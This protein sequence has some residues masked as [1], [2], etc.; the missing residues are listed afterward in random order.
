[1]RLSY[2]LTPLFFALTP[3]SIS[4]QEHNH[5][6]HEHSHSLGAHVHGVATL[7]IA[8]ENQQLEMQ[9]DSP[10]MNIVGFEYKPSSDA[11]KQAVADAERTLKNE[12]ALF[13]LTTAGQCA[14]SSMSID[15]DLI[16]QHDEHEHEH[17]NDHAHAVHSNE[18]DAH[19]H[20]DISAHYVFN[21][22]APSKLNSIDLAGFFKAFPKTEKINVQLVTAEAQNGVELSPSNTV[23]SW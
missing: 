11:D 2:L 14:L 7:N 4:A 1:M 9:L 3:L 16:G 19:Q 20:S 17:D 5:D 22:T 12:Q 23:L 8:L 18:K 13:A 6:D 10:A 21:C 15:N